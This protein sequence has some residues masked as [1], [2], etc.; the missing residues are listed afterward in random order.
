[1]I[2]DIIGGVG[3]QPYWWHY[4]QPIWKHNDGISDDIVDNIIDNLID[5]W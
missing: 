4:R 5:Y 3:W 1:M 2:D